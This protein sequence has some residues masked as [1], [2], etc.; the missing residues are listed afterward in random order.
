[1]MDSVDSRSA[2]IV[3]MLVPAFIWWYSIPVDAEIRAARIEQLESAKECLAAACYGV[4]TTVAWM[5]FPMLACALS[6]ATLNAEACVSR[7]PAIFSS[8]RSWQ[9][10]CEHP[11]SLRESAMNLSLPRLGVWL[12]EWV[13]MVRTFENIVATVR[14]CPNP[15]VDL[16]CGD[17]LQRF[18]LQMKDCLLIIRAAWVHKS[19][20]C[21]AVSSDKISEGQ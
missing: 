15:S 7:N 2:T 17:M 1:M 12:K 5:M 18:L 4:D 6:S 16:A 13:S 19:A 8:V 14:E 20:P 21:C 10:H 11:V 9:R 3:K